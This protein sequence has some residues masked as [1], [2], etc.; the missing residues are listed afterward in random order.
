MKNKYISYILL[1]FIVF[2]GFGTKVEAAEELTCV[3]EGKSGFGAGNDALMF[4]QDSDG[5]ITLY[6][7]VHSDNPDWDHSGWETFSGWTVYSDSQ[8]WQSTN[9]NHS[10]SNDVWG[11]FTG[12][13]NYYGRA[14]GS[15][16][17]YDGESSRYWQGESGDFSNNQLLHSYGSTLLANEPEFVLDELNDIISCDVSD[18]K[19][20]WLNGNDESLSENWTNSC[21]YYYKL[22][23]K[24]TV[25]QLDFNSTNVRVSAKSS[26]G[27]ISPD[28]NIK[29]DAFDIANSYIGGVCP[30][31][32]D[33]IYHS[34]GIFNNSPDRAGGS[35]VDLYLSRQTGLIGNDVPSHYLSRIRSLNENTLIELVPDDDIYV[36]EPG[37]N[38]ENAENCCIELLSQE[39]MNMLSYVILALRIA[40]PLI[41]IGLGVVDFA[42]GV[43]SSEED[44]KK[45]QQKF[46][47]RIILSI[48]FFLIPTVI[49]LLLNIAESAF[50][51][52]TS[53]CGLNLW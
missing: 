7:H 16:Y 15:I 27:I 25:V 33:F 22:A 43:F 40:I 37:E 23:D 3:Y 2:L 26:I 18:L 50:G 44:M 53:F 14:D 8:Y 4:T 19:K 9:S 28:I 34:G 5:N 38:G 30:V 32:L 29:F 21:L 49:N 47:K 45:I 12:C 13:P 24:C 46:I 11:N 35:Y 10:V 42:K 31:N 17:F 41:L 48:G 39:F 20:I 6:K 51:I 52:N 1:V 36:C